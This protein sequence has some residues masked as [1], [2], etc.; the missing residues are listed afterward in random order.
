[1]PKIGTVAS[2]SWLSFLGLASTATAQTLPNGIAAGDVD[3][4]SAILW[5]RSTSVGDI[6]FEYATDPSYSGAESV[7]VSV[8]DAAVPVKVEVGDLVADTRYVYRVTD[9]A[10]ATA[11]GRFRTPAAEGFHGLRFGVSGDWRGDLRPYP[12]ISNVVESDL[13]FFAA[14]GDTIYADIPTPDVPTRQARALDELRRKHNEVYS[15]RFGINTWAEIRST[16]ALYACLDDHE[17]TNDFCGGAPPSTDPR[18]DQNGAFINETDLYHNGM[19]AFQEFNPVRDEFY[20]DTADPRT[21]GKPKLY[22]QRRFGTDAAFFMVD[23]RSFRDASSPRLDHLPNGSELRQFLATAYDPSRTMLGAAQLELLRADLLAAQVDG[24]NWKFVMIPEPIQNLSPV[25]G[26]DRFEGYAHERA[27]LLSFINDNAIENV[28]F[29]TAD[30]HGTIV[31]NVVFRRSP[32]GPQIPTDTFEISTGPVAFAKPLGPATIAYAPPV[33]QAVFNRLDQL[34]R[35]AL[36]LDVIDGLLLI[37]GY[38]QVGLAGSPIDARLLEGRYLAVD[39]FGWT[40]FEI[41]ATTQCLTVTTYG[42]DWYAPEELSAD[43][44]GILSR[45]PEIVSQFRVAPQGPIGTSSSA[46]TD[47]AG[48][49]PRAASTPC[50][51]LGAI[52]AV[53]LGLMPFLG[54][55]A[56]GYGACMRR[57]L[58]RRGSGGTMLRHD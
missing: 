43:P 53:A 19:Q 22:R 39:W 47:G 25:L 57:A 31:N 2:V 7:T 24:V 56:R 20:G 12:S 29:I 41:D 34:G 36:A 40:K 23:A 21:S 13:D 17:M 50:G 4:T 26:S 9:A 46:T 33:L 28:V 37:Y 5:A 32:R 38:P 55:I 45:R 35:D 1:M 49:C 10:G 3:Q 54:I 11:E 44:N 42:I 8:I 14:L 27:E 16:T 15:E 48:S 52:N 58:N 6:V 51:A 18:F 30:I